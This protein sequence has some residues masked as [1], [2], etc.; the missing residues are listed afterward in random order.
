MTFFLNISKLVKNLVSGVH[1]TVTKSHC[2]KYL[3]KHFKKMKNYTD[4][5]VLLRNEKN[6]NSKQL[7][8]VKPRLKKNYVE[9]KNKHIFSHLLTE[10]ECSFYC[11]KL[12]SFSFISCESGM[13]KAR[14][15]CLKVF[16]PCLGLIF[17]PVWK[18]DTTLTII[19]HT[20]LAIAS[21][22]LLV[23]FKISKSSM[24]ISN[25]GG[26]GYSVVQNRPVQSTILG[27]LTFSPQ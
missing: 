6:C 11:F 14:L 23:K 24:R 13:L 2:K 26:L 27:F 5:Y 4:G 9:L 12:L 25:P 19:F 16:H 8:M 1:I 17:L 7:R 10:F 15:L 22:S 20:V 21:D 3:Q 18:R